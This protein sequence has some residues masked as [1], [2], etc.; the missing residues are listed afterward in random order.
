MKQGVAKLR[1]EGQ[2]SHVGTAWL[3]APGLALTAAHCVASRADGRLYP[4][5]LVMEF[6]RPDA[7]PL[8]VGGVE[9]ARF[10]FDLDAALL[11]VPGGRLPAGVGPFVLGT[12]P[13]VD[14]WPL[15]KEAVHWYADG[16]PVA[17]KPGMRLTGFI[18]QPAGRVDNAPALE[19]FCHQ[20]GHG[21]LQGASGAAVCCEGVAVGLIRYGT[22]QQQ[23]IFATAVELIAGTFPE[24]RNQVT[25]ALGR[26]RPVE[27]D[28]N[29]LF[30]ALALQMALIDK[31]QF[32]DVCAGWVTRKH[33][34]LA[35]LLVE[36][37]WLSPE[38]R[39]EVER[40]VQRHLRKNA[41]DVR[42]SPARWPA[43]KSSRRRGRSMTRTS[44]S[45][46][47]ALRGWARSRSSRPPRRRPS[48]FAMW[49]G[50]FRAKAGWA[51]CTQRTTAIST[52]KWPLSGCARTRPATPRRS[53]VSCV[54]R[55]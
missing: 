24:L 23:A 49:C 50:A 40:S 1:F 29:L 15:G 28:R 3:C 34:P 46:W 21:E 5:G 35:E 38:E 2:P 39:Q 7:A 36:R 54:R 33:T 37:G 47:A 51:A 48:S 8:P 4:G 31:E 42:K 27:P 17:H 44:A 18:S 20:G 52:G 19:L 43:P 22:L 53:G 13:K 25:A 10:D 45:R 32:A 9:V 26:L 55:R 14:P 30:G 16:Y 41:G 6:D 12:L 11:R